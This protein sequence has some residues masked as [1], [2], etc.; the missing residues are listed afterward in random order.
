[1]RSISIVE[2]SSLLFFNYFPVAHKGFPREQSLLELLKAMEPRARNY[3]DCLLRKRNDFERFIKGLKVAYKIP[4]IDSSKRT[5][6][7]NGLRGSA[8]QER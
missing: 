6:R 5:Y 7:V 2:Y 3:Q 4:G 8:I 1:M